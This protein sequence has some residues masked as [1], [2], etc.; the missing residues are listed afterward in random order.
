MNRKQIELEIKSLQKQ[1]CD[2]LEKKCILQEKLEKMKSGR[3]KPEVGETFCYIDEEGD[4]YNQEYTGTIREVFLVSKGAAYENVE[5]ALSAKEKKMLTVEFED[6][7]I[8]LNDG[9]QV[10]WQDDDRHKYVIEYEYDGK[11]FEDDYYFTL[12]TSPFFCLDKNFL[13]KSLEKFGE[14]KLKII[15]GIK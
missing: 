11:S 5:V 3:W 7:I 9:V 13:E 15:Y 6:F 2:L 4:I 8:K 12:Q 14:K 10:D 1:T